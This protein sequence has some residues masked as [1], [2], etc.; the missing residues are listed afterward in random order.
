MAASEPREFPGILRHAETI[1][2]PRLAVNWVRSATIC[3]HEFLLLANG[4]TR[5]RVAGALDA[6]W[7]TFR[8]EA[9]VST[10]FCG[11]V[12]PELAIA[13]II[14]A[15]EVAWEG[16]RFPALPVTGA[17]AHRGLVRTL[18]HIAASRAERALL[19]AAGAMAV[20]MEAAE[21][22]ERAQSHGLPFYCIKTVTDLAD[23][24]LENDYN[25]ALRGDGHFD[26]I[27]LLSGALRHPLTRIPE[28]FR[29]RERCVRAARTLGDFFADCRF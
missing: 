20:E 13:D 15:T 8:P 7:E 18:D 3:G 4:A 11:A 26:T 10:G 2:R 16:R 22:A 12:S 1:E 9:V 28:L 23:E 19:C 24:T 27:V 25:G 6:V 14:V 21:A 29:L 5:R 17:R